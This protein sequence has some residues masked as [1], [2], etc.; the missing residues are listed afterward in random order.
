MRWLNNIMY[1]HIPSIRASFI[2]KRISN[3]LSAVIMVFITITNASG[4]FV[5][6]TMIFKY[7]IL[8]GIQIVWILIWNEEYASN[9]HE[10]FPI[11]H[12]QNSIQLFKCNFGKLRG[13]FEMK[14]SFL[15]NG[16]LG[17]NS[18]ILK[19]IDLER[20]LKNH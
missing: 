15:N 9:L 8:A 16:T 2:N 10:N 6:S 13:N 7:F 1:I 14:K 5:K 17:W 11:S 20:K 12:F 4:M 3:I 18:T 19:F